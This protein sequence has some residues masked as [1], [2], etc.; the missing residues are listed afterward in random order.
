LKSFGEALRENSLKPRSYIKRAAETGSLDERIFAVDLSRVHELDVEEAADFFDRTELVQD[1]RELVADVLRRLSGGG[2]SAAYL[3]D[4]KMGGGKSHAMAYLYLILRYDKRAKSREDVRGIL[5]GMDMEDIPAVDVVVFDGMNA[6]SSIAFRDQ[7]G[8][9]PFFDN[10]D[11]KDRIREA[12]DS[13]KRP[14]LFLVDEVLHYL[15]RREEGALKDLDH[16]RSLLEAVVDSQ[17]SAIIVSVPEDD[18]NKEG[19]WMVSGIFK[20]LGKKAKVVQPQ[21]AGRD[22]VR[23][24]KRQIFERVDEAAANEAS[25]WARERYEQAGVPFTGD[26]EQKYSEYYPFHPK[27]VELLVDR[28]PEFQSFMRTRDALKLLAGMC[29]DA[30][31]SSSRAGGEFPTPYLTPGDVALDGLVRER[32]SSYTTFGMKNI[33]GIVNEILGKGLGSEERRVA[34]AVYLYSLHPKKERR[35]L[36]KVE[37]FEA[38][39]TGSPGDLAHLADEYV[40]SKSL[41]MELNE[42]NGKYYFR[43]TPN[44]SSLIRREAERVGDVSVRKQLEV[45]VGE[46]SKG[47]GDMCAVSYDGVPEESKLNLIFA[48]LERFKG[49]ERRR[50]AEEYAEERKFFK[51]ESSAPNSI[52]VV[53]PPDNVDASGLEAVARELTAAEQ[54]QKEYSGDREYI[55]M[56]R[57]EKEKL[58]GDMLAKFVRTYTAALMLQFDANAHRNRSVHEIVRPGEATREAYVEALSGLLKERE[59]AYLKLEDINLGGFFS[60]VLGNSVEAG[61]GEAYSNVK[62]SSRLPFL[63]RALFEEAVRRAVSDGT[64]GLVEGD[65]IVAS[66]ER[67]RD[68]WKIVNRDR[69]QELRRIEAERAR[70]AQV[71]EPS[72]PAAAQAVVPKPHEAGGAHRE[73][74]AYFKVRASIGNEDDMKN[75]GRFLSN[76][77]NVVLSSQ[78]GGE[79]SL[80]ILGDEGGTVLRIP[81]SKVS[82]LKSMIDYLAK[83][84][85]GREYSLEAGVE[86]GEGPARKFR[87]R[88]EKANVRW[89]A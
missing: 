50:S 40:H 12:L 39:L 23:I 63:P 26:L 72:A 6:D 25:R 45:Q 31:A 55:P 85:E 29:A 62:R 77:E 1:L 7:E 78:I 3:L 13:R 38:L 24:A 9:R 88:L 69:L 42:E 16:L 89:G 81:L 86:L 53:Y 52:V 61:V 74:M 51:L 32:L 48:P 2:S 41:Y 73:A 11:A 47:F 58:A 34:T 4:T 8:I 70:P 68:D 64:I 84:A 17:S 22:F 19:Y 49:A 71:V 76:L 15:G 46:L 54:L 65:R 28:L 5:R 67:I 43:E 79:I 59:K 57:R 87:E 20:A 10:G 30:L 27:L 44:V 21:G 35:G 33:D 66:P 36:N 56:L 14:V 80:R 75:L 60:E 18:P 37:L 83:A 82:S